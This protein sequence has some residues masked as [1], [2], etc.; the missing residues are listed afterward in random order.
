MEGSDERAE[1]LPGDHSLHFGEDFSRRPGFLY[2]SKVRA[3]A[4]V[5]CR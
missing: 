2:L 4:R 3:S 1:I 5:F